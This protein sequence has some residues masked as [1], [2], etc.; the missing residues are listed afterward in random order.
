MRCFCTVST[1]SRAGFQGKLFDM[2]ASL[3]SGFVYRPE[4]LTREEELE[5]LGYIEDLPLEHAVGDGK[6]KARRRYMNF[7]WSYNYHT[8][9]LVKGPALP[10]WLTPYA[11]KIA[12]WLDIPQWRV[13]EALVQE[14]SVGSAI[15]WH[16]DNETFEHIIGISLSGW[17]R[18]RLRPIRSRMR[19]PRLLTDVTALE[20]EPRSVY[21]MQRDSRWLFQHSIP[22]TKNLRY[23][24]TFRTLP[25]A[26]RSLASHI[27][28]KVLH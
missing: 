23:S 1:M 18:M 11:R 17:C 15:G 20:L 19:R 22:P 14:Y 27:T 8:G 2:G 6:Y 7:G 9:R 5:L 21:L 24:I 16:R 13:V 3:P 26:Y 4:F 28:K 12:K 25:S 10:H